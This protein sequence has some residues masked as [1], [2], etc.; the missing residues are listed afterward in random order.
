MIKNE[1]LL[2][3]LCA[4]PLTQCDIKNFSLGTSYNHVFP[5]LLLTHYKIELI[6]FHVEK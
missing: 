6:T 1:Y 5:K 3:F 4:T 2:G